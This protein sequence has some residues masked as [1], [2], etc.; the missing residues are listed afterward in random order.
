MDGTV[1]TLSSY[2]YRK[3]VMLTFYGFAS[4]VFRV[5]TFWIF[6]FAVMYGQSKRILSYSFHNDKIIPQEKTM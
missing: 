3:C 5:F 6:Y 1:E 4:F 2:R